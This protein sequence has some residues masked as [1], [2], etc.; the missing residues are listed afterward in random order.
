MTTRE[1][2]VLK[3]RRD[4]R[5]LRYVGGDWGPDWLPTADINKAETFHPTDSRLPDLTEEGDAFEVKVLVV[6]TVTEIVE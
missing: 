1:L 3:L 6:R 4:G 5:Y 2:I